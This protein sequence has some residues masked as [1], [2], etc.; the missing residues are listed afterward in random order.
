MKVYCREEDFN[1][2]YEK[3]WAFYYLNTYNADTWK[4][5]GEIKKA[6]ELNTWL[7][8][9]ELLDIYNKWKSLTD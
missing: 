7:T 4:E 1:L 5:Y 2:F 9:E 6:I 8:T 3:N